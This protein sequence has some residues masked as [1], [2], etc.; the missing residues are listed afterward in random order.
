MST[1][2]HASPPIPPQRRTPERLVFVTEERRE[3]VPGNRHLLVIRKGFLWLTSAQQAL[4]DEPQ[5]LHPV[6]LSSPG[7]KEPQDSVCDRE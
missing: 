6:L 1:G 5:A 3:E 4:R 7:L 2:L